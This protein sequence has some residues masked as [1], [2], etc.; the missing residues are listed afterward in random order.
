MSHIPVMLTE[1]IEA[2]NI[3]DN[4]TYV[5]CTFGA[6]GYT[7]AI[8][9]KADCSVVGIDQDETCKFFA[10][11]LHDEFGQRFQ[12][13]T[14]NFRNIRNL[15]ENFIPVDGIVYDLGVSSMQLDEK[16]R[17]F[18]FQLNAPLDM[19]MGSG[20]LTARDIVNQLEEHEL[21][22]IIYE[23]GGEHKSRKIAKAIINA[24]AIKPIATTHELSA[25]IKSVYGP[26][27]G[28]KIDPATKTFQAIR[29]FVNDEL[30]A[31]QESLEQI[32]QILTIGGRAVFISF[33]E[34]EDRIIKQFC[35]SR[36][37][38]KIASSKYS[39]Q[40]KQAT[41]P[42][43]IISKKAQLPSRNEILSNPRS[44]SAKLRVI[45]KIEVPG[46]N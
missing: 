43:K 39:K 30:G 34:L 40:A 5:D 41:K 11:K 9:Q 15:I 12:H 24:R 19:R 38:P 36:S 33:H 25:I 46:E 13:I 26:K 42:F 23:Y 7:T 3:R 20:E 14:G 44:R 16:A 10:Q 45:E 27:K 4:G 22:N 32:E 17:G 29:I 18:S 2:L 37:D 6:G 28:A 1:A 21:A 35:L 8:L 31:L